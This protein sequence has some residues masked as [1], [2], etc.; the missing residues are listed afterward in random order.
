MGSAFS[1]GDISDR[2]VASGLRFAIWVA[3]KRPVL[4]V[5]WFSNDGLHGHV[6]TLLAFKLGSF[7]RRCAD[8]MFTGVMGLSS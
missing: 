6:E 3:I 4:L 2:L 1:Y 7:G 5:V 8:S